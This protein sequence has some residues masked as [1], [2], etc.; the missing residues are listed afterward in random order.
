MANIRELKDMIVN[1]KVALTKA[2]VP[3]SNCPMHYFTGS[4]IVGLG[5]DAGVSCDVYEYRFFEQY[6]KDCAAEVIKL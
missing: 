1:L 4:S 6:R 3:D 5:C 2:Q